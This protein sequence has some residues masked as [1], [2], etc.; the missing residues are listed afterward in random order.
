VTF[1]VAGV[2]FFSCAKDR[3][4]GGADDDTD[5]PAG[6]GCSSSSSVYEVGAT[7]ESSID[8]GEA[9]GG[10]RTFRVHV[11]PNYDDGK[12]MPVVLMFHGGYGT[13]KQ[14][15]EHSSRMD[16]VADAQ[17]FITVYP[18]G[19]GDIPTWNARICC[20]YTM[21]MDIDDVGFVSRLLDRLEQYLCVDKDRVFAAGMSN[22][23]I[24]THRLA[25][26]L[27]DR[28][29]AIG[30]VAGTDA[31]TDCKPSRPVSVMEIH[32]TGD[33]HVPWD[34]GYGC[35]TSH[36]DYIGVPETVDRWARRDGCSDETEPWLTE[37]DG[38]CTKRTGCPDGVDIVLCAIQGGGHSWPGGEPSAPSENCP[39]DGPQSQT[40]HASEMLWDF[41]KTHPK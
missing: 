9:A 8:A 25:C 40:F 14:L 37:G 19:L 5:A 32:G 18:D 17:G 15:E 20:G 28:I 23:A 13:G 34:G 16:E 31:D 30:P 1:T 27:A 26:E 41:F 4:S 7:T 21:L 3:E 36:A 10:L 38:V 11:P 33:R 29:A 39:E 22:G 6:S 24:L 12:P 35:G 2:V